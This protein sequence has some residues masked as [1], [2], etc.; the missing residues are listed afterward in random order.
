MRFEWDKIKEFVSLEAGKQVVA[1]LILIVG[2]LVSACIFFYNGKSNAEAREMAC[3]KRC[4]QE[5]FQL[6]SD[7]KDSINVISQ[8]NTAVIYSK[9]EAEIAKL[10]AREVEMDAA[11]RRVAQGQFIQRRTSYKINKITKD[12]SQIVTNERQKQ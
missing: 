9:Y 7:Y 10:E 6:L 2:F 4:S 5:K 3:E 1:G 8:R 11:L 12:V